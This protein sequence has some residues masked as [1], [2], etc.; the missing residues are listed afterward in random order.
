[1]V[2]VFLKAWT[3]HYDN[4]LAKRGGGVRGAFMALEIKV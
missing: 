4:L 2:L 1:M 3:S